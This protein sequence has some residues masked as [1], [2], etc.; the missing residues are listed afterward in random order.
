MVPYN[1][2]SEYYDDVVIIK[3]NKNRA[4]V[5]Q[6]G[7]NL[8]IFHHWV[9]INHSEIVYSSYKVVIIDILIEKA[10]FTKLLYFCLLSIWT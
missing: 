3:A 10:Q 2:L 7:E 8:I 1:M 6:K 5:L 9:R 4:W